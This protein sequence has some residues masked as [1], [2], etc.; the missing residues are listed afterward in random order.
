M[1]T[2]EQGLEENHEDISE[3][4]SITNHKDIQE[5]TQTDELK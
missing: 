1:I 4:K 3:G 5:D 2:N